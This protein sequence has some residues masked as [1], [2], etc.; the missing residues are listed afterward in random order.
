MQCN[1]M[2]HCMAL[3]SCRALIRTVRCVGHCAAPNLKSIMCHRVT[4]AP[5]GG[6]PMNHGDKVYRA[7]IYG[8]SISSNVARLDAMIL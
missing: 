6:G 8:N 1:T 3:P 5:T 4:P 7:T 2:M